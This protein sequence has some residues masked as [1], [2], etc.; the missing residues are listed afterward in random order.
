MTVTIMVTVAT[1]T[2]D[3][4]GIKRGKGRGKRKRRKEY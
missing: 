4:E 1:D 2:T 3:E